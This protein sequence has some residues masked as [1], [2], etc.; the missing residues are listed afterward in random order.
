MTTTI[1]LLTTATTATAAL[2]AV[3]V[4]AKEAKEAAFRASAIATAAALN[5]GVEAKALAAA[6]K[7]LGSGYG[8][9]AAVGFH[10]VTGDFL[11]L[12][13]DF[14]GAAQSVQNRIKTVGQPVAKAI[15]KKSKDKGQADA[16]TRLDIKIAALEVD[17]VKVLTAAL[18]TVQ[19]AEEARVGGAPLPADAVGVIE[20]ITAALL[21]CSAKSSQPVLV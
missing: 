3:G 6:N 15:L 16:V 18:K 17:I 8:S 12:E 10:A 1:T 9:P 2:H 7:A 11:A 14:E 5:G 21:N 19:K 20:S 13:A 4:D